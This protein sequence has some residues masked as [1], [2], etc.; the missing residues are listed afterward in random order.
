MNAWEREIATLSFSNKGLDR[1]CIEESMYPWDKTVNNWKEQG[2]DTGF[3]DKV[4]FATLPTDN[5]YAYNEPYEPWQDYY[6]TMMAEPVFVHETG[7]GW[8]PVM[9]IAFR[10]PFISYKE[11]IREETDEYIIRRDRDGWLRR[12]PKNGGLVTDV[13]PVVTCMEEWQAHKAHIQEQIKLH[14]TQENMEKAYGRFRE[15][16]K[17]KDYV[18]HLRL[19][20]FF[21]TPRFLFG[22]EEQLYAYYDEPE[23]LQDISRFV[24]DVYKEQLEGILKIVTPSVVFFEEDLSGKNGPM[25]SPATF[26]E[27]ISP[28]YRE[29]VPFLRERGV[30]NVIMDTDGDFTVMIP[31]ILECGLDGVLPV[32]VNAGVD[33]V[34]VRE[35]YPTLKFIG[36]FNKLSI[37]DGEDAIEKEL[38]RLRPVIKQGGCII[39]TDHQ[40]APHTPLKYYQYYSRRL[41]E[42]MAELR[43]ERVKIG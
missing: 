1:G 8:D 17:N 6:N 25:I 39:C 32:D 40:A 23:V 4:H 10:I 29:L 14:L 9:R 3:L 37:I 11:E 19:S 27:F 41:K 22:N 5:L 24:T 34:K 12:Y 43:N 21:W 38:D 33:I 36:G 18:V 2:Y 42:V 13:K 16:C 28:Y 7:L 30:Q 31:K 35:Q 26:E 20:G 15:G